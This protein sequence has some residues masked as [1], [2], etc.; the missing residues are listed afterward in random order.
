MKPI[1]TKRSNFTYRG[2]TSGIGDLPCER[3]DEE[4]GGHRYRVVYSVWEPTPEEREFVAKGGNIKLGIVGMEPIPPVSLQ[5]VH[6][7][8][9]IFEG[10]EPN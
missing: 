8:M 2:P 10:V 9:P 7:G 5:I 3:T 6:E 1:R 4:I